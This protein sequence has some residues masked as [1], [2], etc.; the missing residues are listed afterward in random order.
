[1]S[2]NIEDL[3]QDIIDNFEHYTPIEIMLS[4]KIKDLKAEN[5]RLKSEIKIKYVI[6]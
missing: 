3:A 1:M 2:E 5:E 6:I 4:K